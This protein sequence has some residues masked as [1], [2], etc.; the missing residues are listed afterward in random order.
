MKRN[1]GFTLIEMIV[2]IA[3]LGI[4]STAILATI[5]PF[6]QLQKS[7]DTRRKADLES[8]QHAL[9]LYY[10][11]NDKYPDSSADFQILNGATTVAWG[12]SWQPYMATLPKDPSL[13]S[14]YVYYSPSTANGQTYYL[15]ANLQRGSKDPQACNKGNACAS[16]GSASG[17]PAANAC[18]GT[19]NYGVSSTNVSP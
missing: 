10:Q 13:S 11:D 5:D 2:V 6:G 18:G 3:L 12:S 17:F 8:I 15:Y 9:E 16:I 14:S 19:C 4:I 1:S 7:N